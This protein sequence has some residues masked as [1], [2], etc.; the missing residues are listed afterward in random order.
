MRF[1]EVYTTVA[2]KEAILADSKATEQQKTEE[3]K[4]K[5]ISE[6]SYLQSELLQVL[7]DKVNDLRLKN[8]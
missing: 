2:K 5:I 4:K 3:N 6:E 8:G 7:I 1:Q